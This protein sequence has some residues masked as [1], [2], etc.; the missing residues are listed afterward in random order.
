MGDVLNVEGRERSITDV[1]VRYATRVA[2]SFP[3][4]LHLDDKPCLVVGSDLEARDRALALCEAGARVE[5]VSATPC[6]EL[7]EFTA[8]RSVPLAQRAF[9][10][11]DLND[12]WLAV[13][14]DRDFE[15]GARLAALCDERR[16]LFCAVDQPQKNS[17]SH[18][19]LARAGV[20]V[21]AIGTN[22]RVPAL[23]RRL[24][25]ELER[26]FE[27]AGLAAFADRLAALRDSVTPDQR[28]SVLGALTS[29][30]RFEGRL[31]LEP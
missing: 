24:R 21:V 13:L 7:V 3:L 28:R 25:Q 19:A 29:A 18:L 17:F 23:G 22:G 15:L 10:P 1:P 27:E 26:V 30:V 12:K 6:P 14:V 5:V 31:R 9:V 4:A 16:I 8:L 2:T 11:D 20:V